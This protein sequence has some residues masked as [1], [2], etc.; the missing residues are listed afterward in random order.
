MVPSLTLS[1]I[2]KHEHEHVD[3]WDARGAWELCTYG[4][5]HIHWK[6]KR[7]IPPSAGWFGLAYI[8][9][10]HLQQAHVLPRACLYTAITTPPR[11]AR[12]HPS[13]NLKLIPPLGRHMSTRQRAMRH[14]LVRRQQHL[15]MQMH[16]RMDP[17]PHGPP[18]RLGHLPLVHRPQPIHP[19]VLDPPKRRHIFRDERKVLLPP[20]VS[21]YPPSF[22]VVRKHTR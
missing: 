8:V 12:S 9:Q 2:L 7:R 13:P 15:R 11:Y 22:L 19:A 6:G 16:T 14:I 3:R 1:G 5:V 18:N 4:M 10:L 20:I 17:Q 21:T